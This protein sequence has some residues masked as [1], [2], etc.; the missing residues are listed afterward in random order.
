MVVVFLTVK[1]SDIA[2]GLDSGFLLRNSGFP[3]MEI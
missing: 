3:A 2:T 1:M